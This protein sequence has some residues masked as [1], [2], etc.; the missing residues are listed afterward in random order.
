MLFRS[1][2]GE[3]YEIDVGIQEVKNSAILPL[4]FLEM[5]GE[6]LMTLDSMYNNDEKLYALKNQFVSYINISKILFLITTPQ[7]CTE[8][9]YTFDELFETL[10][11]LNVA[12]PVGVIITKIDSVSIDKIDLESYIQ[13]KMPATYKWILQKKENVPI[14]TFFYSTGT[15]DSKDPKLY[16]II[17]KNHQSY[18]GEVL[19]WICDILE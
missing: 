15:P 17:K 19:N 12:L 1:N 4:T 14:R 8:D 10:E 2:R 16:K 9:D 11:L 18:A 5:S 7:T 13:S 3:I 6:D